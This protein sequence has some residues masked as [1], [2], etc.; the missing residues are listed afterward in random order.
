METLWDLLKHHYEINFNIPGYII[1]YIAIKDIIRDCVV[2]Y[3][4]STIARRNK[5]KVSYVLEVLTGYLWF[6]GWLDDLDFSPMALYEKSNG[7]KLAYEQEINMVSSFSQVIVDMS[8]E[9][10]R[11]YEQ[12]EKELEKYYDKI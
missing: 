3:S 2:G 9:I 8:F 1:D 12:I 10:C 4:N 6:T 5:Q 7:I 11:R